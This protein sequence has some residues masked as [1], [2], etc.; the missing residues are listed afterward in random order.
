MFNPQLT[1]TVNNATRFGGRTINTAPDVSLT[2]NSFDGINGAAQIE[3]TTDAAWDQ[4]T[5]DINVDVIFL[6]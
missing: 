4:T 3:I 1:Y 2:Y 6:G 5:A